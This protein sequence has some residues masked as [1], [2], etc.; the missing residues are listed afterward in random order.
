MFPECEFD[1]LVEIPSPSC[2]LQKKK[3]DE[4]E[5]NLIEKQSFKLIFDRHYHALCA[6]SYRYLN[7]TASAEDMIQEVFVRFWEL[8]ENFENEKAIKA[9]LFTSVR[10]NCLNY[11]KHQAVL[12][13]HEEQLIYELET[14]H[15]F[16]NHIVEEEAFKQLYLEIEQLPEAAQKIMV[17]VLKGLKNKEIAEELGISENTVKTQKKISYSKLKKKLSPTMTAILLSF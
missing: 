7:D 15:F 2:G 12:K 13:K 9:F 8:R 5:A 11:L 14:E 3:D 10:N 1:K 16:T 6:F 17:L 4:K